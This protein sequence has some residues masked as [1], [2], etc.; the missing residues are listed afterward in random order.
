MTSFAGW[1]QAQQAQPER[2]QTVFVIAMENHNWTQPAASST[3][4]P[5]IKGNAAAP[6]INAL[7]NGSA[8]ATVGGVTTNISAQTAYAAAYRNVLANT[9]AHIHPSEP[10]YIWAEAGT[11]FSVKNDNPPYGSGGNNQTTSQHLSTLLANAG[12]SWKSYQEDIDLAKNSLGMTT[13]TVLPV[14][15]WS[16]PLTAVSGISLAYTNRYNGS[17]QFSYQPKHNPPL[18]F[19][20]TNG[21][22]DSTPANPAVKHYAPLDQLEIDLA[23]NTVARYNWISPNIYNDMHDALLSGF[24]YNGVKYT[25]QQAKIA[26]GDNFLRQIVPMIM[27]SKAYKNNGVIILWWDE[28]EA[29]TLFENADDL[30]HTIPEIIISPLAHPNV[31][32]KPYASTVNLSHSDDLRTMQNIFGVDQGGYLGDAASAQGLDS[33]FVAGAVAPR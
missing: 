4:Q 21:G 29:A 20:D 10:N 12:I 17:H 28:T 5:Q 27:A 31:A 16:V 26:Q 2:I 6:F 8:S 30:N 1:A 32:G 13:N 3:S 24:T 25:G 11:N 19:A 23:N 14:E 9:S 22:N 7:V 18:F 15:Q 33:L